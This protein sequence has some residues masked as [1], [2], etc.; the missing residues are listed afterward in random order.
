[1]KINFQKNNKLYIRK[2]LEKYLKNLSY[3]GTPAPKKGST[4]ADAYKQFFEFILLNLRLSFLKS[5]EDFYR[6]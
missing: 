6:F 1:M 5:L 2:K 3:F 4:K